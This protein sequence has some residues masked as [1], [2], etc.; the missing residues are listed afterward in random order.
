MRNARRFRQSRRRSPAEAGPHASFVRPGPPW[1]AGHFLAP[2]GPWRSS[3]T[4]RDESSGWLHR[5]TRGSA[6]WTH[7]GNRRRQTGTAAHGHRGDRSPRGSVAQHGVVCAQRQTP[8]VH[9]HAQTYPRRDAAAQVDLDV[10]LS[11][12]GEDHDRSFEHTLRA[13]V[14]A[15]GA[16]V[17]GSAAVACQAPPGRAG[18]RRQPSAPRRV[19]THRR[20]SRSVWCDRRSRLRPAASR[21]TGVSVQDPSSNDVAS[22]PRLIPAVSDMSHTM[23]EPARRALGQGAAPNPL[24][25]RAPPGS[26]PPPVVQVQRRSAGLGLPAVSA[27]VP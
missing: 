16:R 21:R 18:S 14:A 25:E 17:S 8:R 2:L 12:S 10:L 15:A 4:V 26:L 19:S 23:R 1:C 27:T 6:P 5:R 13:A 20:R 9:Q 3:S 7:M 11:P 22:V 24:T